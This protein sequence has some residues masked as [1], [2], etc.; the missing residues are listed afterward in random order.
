MDGKPGED[1]V[2]DDAVE[3]AVCKLMEF[4]EEK[5]VRQIPEGEQ[6][7]VCK[8]RLANPVAAETIPLSEYP[9]DNY[10]WRLDFFE[11]NTREVAENRRMIYSP[12][13]YL[14]AYWMGRYHGLIPEGM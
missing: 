11:I 4:P 6:E 8:S 14:L 3:A 12:E 13:D 1:A 10:L 2:L 7:E 9:F 5:F